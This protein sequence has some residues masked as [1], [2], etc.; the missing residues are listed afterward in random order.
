MSDGHDLTTAL[1]EVADAHRT[2]PRI[3]GSE[4][5]RR[6]AWRRRRRHGALA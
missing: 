5:R 6:A 2:P 4:I 1:R 3:P